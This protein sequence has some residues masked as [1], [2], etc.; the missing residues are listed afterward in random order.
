MKQL[1]AL[2]KDGRVQFALF[3]DDTD[4]LVPF[5][6]ITVPFPERFGLAEAAV[7]GA[8]LVEVMGLNGHVKRGPGRPRKEQA[9][10]LELEEASTPEPKQRG[11]RNIRPYI[12]SE[13]VVA[14]VNEHHAGVTIAYV[15]RELMERHDLDED[16]A[17]N[18][19]VKAVSNRVQQMET[20]AK[21]G[22]EPLPIRIEAQPTIRQDGTPSALVSKYLYP[23]RGGS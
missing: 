11:R 6:E 23:L 19:L 9:P 17:K 22:K 8:N 16:D 4:Q 14:V 7:L 13:E 12:S 5:A 2:I 1:V 20:R 21:E 10:Q 15:S 3:D 18:W